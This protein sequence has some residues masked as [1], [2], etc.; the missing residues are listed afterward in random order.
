VAVF[1]NGYMELVPTC[2]L[3]PDRVNG[4]GR[5]MLNETLAAEYEI[6]SGHGP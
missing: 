3:Q 6:L 2:H 4:G 5:C 1:I